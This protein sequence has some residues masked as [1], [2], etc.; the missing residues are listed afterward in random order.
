MWTVK[1]F[2]KPSEKE[3]QNIVSVSV[4]GKPVYNMVK[5]IDSFSF[6]LDIMEECS[7]LEVVK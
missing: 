3:G 5:E 6:L 4:F 2:L 7:D 1:V